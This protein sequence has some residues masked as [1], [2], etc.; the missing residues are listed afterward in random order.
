MTIYDINDNIT[1]EH[2]LSKTIIHKNNGV[3]WVILK[4]L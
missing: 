1:I 2:D 3:P 4:L